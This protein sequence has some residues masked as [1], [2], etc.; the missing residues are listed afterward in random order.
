MEVQQD[1]LE[2]SIKGKETIIDFKQANKPKKIDYMLKIGL[3]LEHIL[4]P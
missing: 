4:G 1:C 3:A 2:F